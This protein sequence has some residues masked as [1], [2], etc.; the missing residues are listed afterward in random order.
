MTNSRV[1]KIAPKILLSSKESI[2]VSRWRFQAGQ[3]EP[4]TT[5]NGKFA[6]KS[7]S[8]LGSARAEDSIKR[9]ISATG[10]AAS[11]TRV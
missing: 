10:I 8:R 9:P 1:P 11:P 4:E 2:T 5:R 6:F 3:T 7:A